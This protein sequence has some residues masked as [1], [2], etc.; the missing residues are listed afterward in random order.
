MRINN[1]EEGLSSTYLKL[2][3]ILD[4]TAYKSMV[5]VSIMCPM[6]RRTTGNTRY[7]VGRNVFRKAALEGRI[8]GFKKF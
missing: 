3:H 1:G 8:S 4:K 7:G 6:T 2:R 5:K